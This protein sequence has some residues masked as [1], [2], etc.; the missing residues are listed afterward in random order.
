MLYCLNPLA[1]P[2]QIALARQRVVV[3][4]VANTK[5]VRRGGD[6]RGHGCRLQARKDIETVSEIKTKYSAACSD[7]GVGSWKLISL[8]RVRHRAFSVARPM[9]FATPVC[10]VRTAMTL[11]R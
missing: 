5:I 2:L 7:D 4:A 11:L 10:R 8:P 6:D 1:R 9:W 3:A